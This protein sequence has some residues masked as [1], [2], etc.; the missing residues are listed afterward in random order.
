M[1][2]VIITLIITL[3]WKLDV[4]FLIAALASI[5]SAMF[6]NVGDEEVL[7]SGELVMGGRE[8]LIKSR[9]VEWF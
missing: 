3:Y 6:L 8:A 4:V 7:R 5:L 1:C 2:F 9:V